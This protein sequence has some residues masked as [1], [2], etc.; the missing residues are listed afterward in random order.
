[1]IGS[2]LTFVLGGG[3]GFAVGKG[4]AAK[5]NEEQE[6]EVKEL[7]R[8]V[9]AANARSGPMPAILPASS[10]REP[11]RSAIINLPVD[12][13][14]F[15][16]LHEAV[17]ACALALRAELAAGNVITSEDLSACVL[18]A[19]YP[20][21]VW[22]PVPGDPSEAH[23]L[24]LIVDHESRKTLADPSICPDTRREVGGSP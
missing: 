17:C 14:D 20:D 7:K 19:I 11:D 24:K 2:F 23:L 1:M 15:D 5:K 16:Q 21:F 9:A 4:L 13:E 8:L 18:E 3:L 10:Y 6:A 22:P 12:R